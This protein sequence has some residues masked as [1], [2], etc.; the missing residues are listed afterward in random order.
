MR[1]GAPGPRAIRSSH[2]HERARRGSWQAVGPEDVTLRCGNFKP[3][4]LALVESPSH[5]YV[6][7][8]AVG[9]REAKTSN[10]RT[11]STVKPAAASILKLGT[12]RRWQEAP[13]PVPTVGAGGGGGLCWAE[14]RRHADQTASPSRSGSAVSARAAGASYLVPGFPCSG[15]CRPLL[16]PTYAPWSGAGPPSLPLCEQQPPPTVSAFLGTHQLPGTGLAFPAPQREPGHVLHWGAW[17]AS[18][19]FYQLQ[20]F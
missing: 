9:R 5:C 20:R 7:E 3:V 1:G 13:G 2:R 16:G 6:T 19:S 8:T 14:P 18:G 15:P 11:C 4:A 10:A 12:H 17:G